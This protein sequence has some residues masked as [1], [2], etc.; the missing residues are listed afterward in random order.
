MKRI[1]LGHVMF[2]SDPSL[3]SHAPPLQSKG[4]HQFDVQVMTLDKATQLAGFSILRPTW[5]PSTKLSLDRVS[6]KSLLSPTLQQVVGSILKYRGDGSQ[7]L[8]IEQERI[9]D[10]RKLTVPFDAWERKI[11]NHAAV[12]FWQSVSATAQPTGSINVLQALWEEDD[13]LMRVRGYGFEAEQMTRI[14]ESLR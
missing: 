2:V 6:L 10:M 7:W 1:N 4:Q 9:R 13:F 8:A 3:L 12:F 14:G 11:N 5:L